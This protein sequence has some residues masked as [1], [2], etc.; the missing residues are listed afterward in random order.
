MLKWT[1]ILIATICAIAGVRPVDTHAAD[2][3]GKCS[4]APRQ[5]FACSSATGRVLVAPEV[6]VGARLLSTRIVGMSSFPVSPLRSDLAASVVH[7]TCG[8]RYQSIVS[9]PA[10]SVTAFR[11][12]A[13]LA[14]PAIAAPAPAPVWIVPEA[15]VSPRSLAGLP[16]V[17]IR[18]PGPMNRKKGDSGACSAS[19]K[20]TPRSQD[21][22]CSPEKLERLAIRLEALDARLARLEKTLT[23]PAGVDGQKSGSAGKQSSQSGRGVRHKRVRKERATR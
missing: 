7:G 16:A 9:S 18:S 3:D 2:A 17:V 12:A 10:R 6:P 1:A 21:S 4:A 13:S 20:E 14:S 15:Q 23:P 22:C 19:A 5:A 8:A 11:Y